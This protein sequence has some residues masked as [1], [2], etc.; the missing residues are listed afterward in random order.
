MAEPCK[1]P[2][3]YFILAAVSN[4]CCSPESPH[5]HTQQCPKPTPWRDTLLT[6]VCVCACMYAQTLICL[7]LGQSKCSRNPAQQ[8]FLQISL[9]CPQGNFSQFNCLGGL[10]PCGILF[11]NIPVKISFWQGRKERVK[12]LFFFK[13]P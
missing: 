5:L 2:D 3:C 8:L 6:C 4:H 1:W 12:Y 7:S 13:S 11:Q 9:V 10:F